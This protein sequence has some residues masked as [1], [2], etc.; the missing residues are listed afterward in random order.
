M[1]QLLL[2]SVACPIFGAVACSSGSSD[3]EPAIE[4]VA[5]NVRFTS[6]RIEVPAGQMVTLK[7]KN[8]ASTEHDL[9][10]RGLTPSSISGGGHEG[11]GDPIR[12][13]KTVAVHTY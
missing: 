7:L 13:T 5:Q 3:G 8:L 6:A 10:V 9:E 1:K 11:P 12:L 2:L 4:V